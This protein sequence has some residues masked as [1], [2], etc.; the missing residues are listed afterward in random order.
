MTRPNLEGLTTRELATLRDWAIKA[1]ET[2]GP[3]YVAIEDELCTKGVCHH[4]NRESLAAGAVPEMEA[5]GRGVRLGNYPRVVI[6]SSQII[7]P[8]LGASTP[9]TYV[10][11]ASTL[12]LPPG[13]WPSQLQIRLGRRFYL[14]EGI[15]APDGQFGGMRYETAD[16][17]AVA[18]LDVLND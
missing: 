6:D 10:A 4:R 9:P 1:G 11:E 7:A 5:V 12:H 15:L 2:D 8:P 14:K 18:R 3:L 13:R 16:G 17:Q